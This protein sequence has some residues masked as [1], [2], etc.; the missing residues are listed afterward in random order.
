MGIHSL[1]PQLLKI[2]D[3]T[4]LPATI[5]SRRILCSEE[6]EARVSFDNFLSLSNEQLPVI[7]QQSI[8]S[9][10]NISGSQVQFI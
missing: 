5:E 8:E 7:I 2:R 3:Y 6:H 1:E 9:L 10:Q 4:D